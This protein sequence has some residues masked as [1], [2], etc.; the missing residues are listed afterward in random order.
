MTWKKLTV[1]QNTD[2]NYQSPLLIA[3]CRL[4]CCWNLHAMQPPPPRSSA[5]LGMGS[6]A[7]NAPPIFLAR[8]PGG[9]VTELR[10]HELQRS[11]MTTELI[12]LTNDTKSNDP[13]VSVE[14]IP[15]SGTQLTRVAAPITSPHNTV[16]SARWT[17]W[18]QRGRP[19]VVILSVIFVTPLVCIAVH[20]V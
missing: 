7:A 14:T 15:P 2:A 17:L 11:R 12:Q 19:F 1:N 20:I 6:K 8:R 13:S 18:V 10:T 16:S 4:S 3:F 9:G 5:T